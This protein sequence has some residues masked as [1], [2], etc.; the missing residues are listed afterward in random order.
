ML[1]FPALHVKLFCRVFN[2]KERTRNSPFS[3]APQM[4]LLLM[5]LFLCDTPAILT[6]P[7]V[8]TSSTSS[9]STEC[10]QKRGKCPPGCFLKN[11]N[12]CGPCTPN[13]T[14]TEYLNTLSECLMCPICD[15]G[16]SL[17]DTTCEICPE[18][19]FSDVISANDTCQ[20]HKSCEALGLSTLENGTPKTNSYCGVPSSEKSPESTIVTEQNGSSKTNFWQ[21]FL[22]ILF[23]AVIVVLGVCLL[24]YCVCKRK[25][26]ENRQPPTTP[27]CNEAP[28]DSAQSHEG[29]P[30]DTVPGPNTNIYNTH[31]NIENAK[32]FQIGHNN[33]LHNS[34]SK[35]KLLSDTD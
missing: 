13:K 9:D 26:Q 6:T 4:F 24:L 22:W 3:M 33:K 31:I 12:S 7:N 35:T 15:S 23:A 19:Y 5:L 28:S 18:N 16:T 2:P 10:V 8:Q 14:Y 1:G 27:L 21:K 11:K 25:Y 30:Q 32:N 17:K 20:P 29:S 34:H